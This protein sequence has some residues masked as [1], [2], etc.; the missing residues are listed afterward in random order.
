MSSPDLPAA[1][2]PV[3]APVAGPDALCVELVRIIDAFIPVVD[4][5]AAGSGGGG[6]PN[7]GSPNGG[8]PN[9]GSPNGGSPNGVAAQLR[10]H[11]IRLLE[12]LRVA[13]SGA[14]SAGK[15]TLLNALVGRDIAPTGAAETTQLVTWYRGGDVEYA[16]MRLVDGTTRQVHLTESG[17]FPDSLDVPAAQIESLHVV[18]PSAPLLRSMTL[19]DTPGLFSL[20][21]ENSERTR[22]ALSPGGSGYPDVDALLF[23]LN[24][25]QSE[26]Q[27]LDAFSQ[28]AS[29]VQAQAANVVGVLSKVDQVGD[30]RPPLDLGRDRAARLAAEPQLRLKIAEIVPVI[31]LVA[32]TARSAQLRYRDIEVL[33]LLA[34]DELV[35]FLLMSADYLTESESQAGGAGRT[36]LLELLGLQG[37]REA[38][39]LVRAGCDDVDELNAGL[40]GWSGFEGLESAIWRTFGPRA[41]A[42]KALSAIAA[43]QRL[44]YQLPDHVGS[45]L[46]TAL[47][48]FLVAPSAHALREL[49]AL[50][51]IV[52]GGVTVPDWVSTALIQIVNGSG[53]HARLGLAP[54]ADDAELYRVAVEQAQR[55]HRFATRPL[56]SQGSA[57]VGEVLRTSYA[58]IAAQHGGAQHGAAERAVDST[59]AGAP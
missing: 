34:G 36:R 27:I 26:V 38:L 17:Q 23:L 42:I 57:A 37:L 1:A 39:R 55:A 50:Q 30:E 49:W 14:V 3:A 32:Q 6:S 20:R 56:V 19:V 22:R 59:T 47:E 21:D 7:G 24:G 18:L 40:L 44:S 45:S 54:D 16:Q 29:L 8:S 2:R 25:Q 5:P 35:E 52:N 53:G 33:R 28:D 46:R 48:G 51:Q 4:A 41:D 31:G 43:L 9:G 15:S 12:P 11:R 58:N 13:L 10:Q